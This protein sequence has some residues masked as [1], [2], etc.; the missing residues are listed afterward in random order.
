MQL[1]PRVFIVNQAKLDLTQ[2]VID[3]VKKHNL[4][5]HELVQVVTAVCYEE[6]GRHAKFGIRRERHGTTNCEGDPKDG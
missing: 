1:H 4:T 3:M 6:V 5:E 2:A